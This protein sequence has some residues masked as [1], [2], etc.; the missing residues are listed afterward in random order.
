MFCRRW[1]ERRVIHIDHLVHRPDRWKEAVGSELWVRR[2]GV[3]RAA[4]NYHLQGSKWPQ[5]EPRGEATRRPHGQDENDIPSSP[6][7]FAPPISAIAFYGCT[8][9]SGSMA[10]PQNGRPHLRHPNSQ[11]TG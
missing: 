3:N 5:A 11:G 6:T 1:R 4:A 8:K 9:R 10:S 7:L 2:R